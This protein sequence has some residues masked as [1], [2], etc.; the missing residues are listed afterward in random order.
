MSFESRL[1][2]V[3]SES[4]SA[5]RIRQYKEL[6][7]NTK[8]ARDQATVLARIISEYAI[9]SKH[10]DAIR[11]ADKLAIH[12]G[13]PDLS[14]VSVWLWSLFL[15]V[16]K[17]G[18]AFRMCVGLMAFCLRWRLRPFANF[19]HVRAV[20]FAHFWKDIRTCRSHALF[21][22]CCAE[23]ETETARA[24]SWL[25][26]SHAY[27]GGGWI[28]IPL[29]RRALALLHKQNDTECLAQN[30]PL[31]AIAYSM[32]GNPSRSH[33][34]HRLFLAR[35][36]GEN[37]FYRLL[38]LTTL[39]NVA[40]ENGDFAA[41]RRLIDRCFAQSFGLVAS[42]HHIQIY[43]W[44]S[45]LHAAE[46]REEE[47]NTAISQSRKAALQTE[48]PL[49]WTIHFRLV[50]LTQLLL[51]DRVAASES[52]LEGRRYCAEYGNPAYYVK[53][54]DNVD[55]ALCQPCSGMGTRYLSWLFENAHR[56]AI[57]CD[58]PTSAPQEATFYR[59]GHR[60]SSAL[61]SSFGFSLELPF[62]EERLIS[63]LGRTFASDCVLVS[64]SA[65]ELRATA[66]RKLGGESLSMPSATDGDVRLV[67]DDGALFIGCTGPTTDEV[68]Q[69]IAVGILLRD[70]DLATEALHQTALRMLL[71]HF[72]TAKSIRISRQRYAAEQR[73]AAIGRLTRMFA[74]D[75][76]QPF[77]I[78]KVLVESLGQ[79]ENPAEFKELASEFQGELE[80]SVTSVEA[81][82]EDVLEMD[83]KEKVI[84]TSIPLSSVLNAAVHQ[85]ARV[86]ADSDV[87]FS[88]Q[89]D[90]THE[91][92][93]DEVRLLRV[94]SNLVTNAIEAMKDRG[95][96][97]LK[98]SDRTMGDKQFVEVVVSDTGHGIEPGDLE[99]V[100]DPLF[101]KGKSQGTGLGLAI[102]RKIVEAH[103]GKIGARS[104]AT[105]AEFW[106]QLPA[107]QKDT[108][109]ATRLPSSCREVVSRHL[110]FMG[111][112]LKAP[113]R[114]DDLIHTENLLLSK[115]K[116]H[117][118]GLRLAVIDDEAIYQKY[119]A[120]QVAS[121]KLA[122]F[123]DVHGFFGAKDLGLFVA[124]LFIV[125]IELGEQ[126]SGLSVV[127]R[128]RTTNPNSAIV[129]H[130]NSID[131]EHFRAAAEL[132]ADVFLPKPM[133]RLHLL[134]ALH[135]SLDTEILERAS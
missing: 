6:S 89:F 11:W 120:Q 55:A 114:Q 47:A 77:S 128:L 121:S 4:D 58:R 51:G 74:H 93:A 10:G 92:L 84:S 90:H 94:I 125:D 111:R 28:G 106:L 110:P 3:E 18:R 46:G 79:I 43:G 69:P 65:E 67:G 24:L 91:V 82:I 12:I 53:S 15:F 5:V 37:A 52:V 118:E 78:L 40:F 133:S 64:G 71:T 86:K 31:L 25:G 115:L 42:R 61:S 57:S 54:L 119:L 2:Q 34:Y 36:A 131:S 103:G 76:R 39:Q 122:D 17:G 96:V 88:Y 98:T 27:G 112:V 35:Y 30:Y 63:A 1:T 44:L 95:T 23:N 49:D 127:R 22:L 60:L 73:A 38:A 117:G 83:R 70:V 75:V 56:Y 126:E 66:L 134:K 105:G 129:V 19:T 50:A 7:T 62:T 59:L 81:L 101:T 8:N 99:L 9:V 32:N 29:L 14:V 108:E 48:D 124:D 100:F 85:V 80:R 72:V 97:S 45:V 107:G 102:A 21:L 87:D 135:L 20:E 68:E 113:E 13:L 16:T 41:L 132:G 123:V 130:S 109:L 104:K 26:Y 116:G 33:H